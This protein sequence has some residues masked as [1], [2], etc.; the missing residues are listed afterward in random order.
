MSEIYDS[1]RLDEGTFQ[2]KLKIKFQYQHNYGINS[3]PVWGAG[4]EAESNGRAAVVWAGVNRPGGG[5]GDDSGGG[6][7]P[8]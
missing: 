8:R 7:I 1:N 2:I 3:G 5:K 6:V 4:E